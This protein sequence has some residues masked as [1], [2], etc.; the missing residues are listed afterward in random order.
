MK[1]LRGQLSRMALAAREAM[2]KH[3]LRAYADRGYFNSPETKV[4]SDAG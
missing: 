3:K 2:G 1:T 4:C